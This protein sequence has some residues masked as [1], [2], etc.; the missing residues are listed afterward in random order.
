MGNTISSN[1]AS[2]AAQQRQA[3]QARQA[4][5]QRQAEQARQAQQAQQAQQ[6]SGSQEQKPDTQVGA[7]STVARE[8]HR[9][10]Y[11]P[12]SQSAAGVSQP[13]ESSSTAN[14]GPVEKGD[15]SASRQ[16][17]E[18]GCGP[19]NVIQL[20]LADS[21]NQLSTS[22][23]TQ[24][25]AQGIDRAN[26]SSAIQDKGVKVNLTQGTTPNEMAVLLGEQSQ[27]VV[28]GFD[29]YDAGYL[30]DAINKGQKALALVDSNAL[31][32]EGKNAPPGPLHWIT[33][34]KVDQKGTASN[35]DDDVFTV[36]DPATG[37]KYSLSEQQLKGATEKARE[38]TGTGGVLV[39]EHDESVKTDAQREQLAL[40]NLNHATLLGDDD[41]GHRGSYFSGSASTN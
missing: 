7:Q 14:G 2:M 25:V 32:P 31:G 4:E 20:T 37:T 23:A 1:S 26:A 3:E 41:G 8:Y 13:I 16:T 40:E 6:S 29:N 39:V 33:I 21:N 18:N 9:D 28:R 34:D 19:T 38:Q 36:S 22:A 15:V 27:R 11:D 24:Q 35:P 12:Q 10:A 5:L 17:T 30:N